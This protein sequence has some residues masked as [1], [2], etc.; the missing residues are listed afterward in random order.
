MKLYISN[1][2]QTMSNILFS[3]NHIEYKY[4]DFTNK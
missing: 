1:T 3:S 4:I 2:M